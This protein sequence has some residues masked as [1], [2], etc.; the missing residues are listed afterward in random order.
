MI[1]RLIINSQT[2]FFIFG[3]SYFEDDFNLI[4]V[5]INLFAYLL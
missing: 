3:S 2:L 4:N 5:K 1:K